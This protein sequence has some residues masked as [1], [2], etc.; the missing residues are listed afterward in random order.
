MIRVPAIA[1]WSAD[2]DAGEDLFGAPHRDNKHGREC[3]DPEGSRNE[4]LNVEQ[5]NGQ[6]DS[7]LSDRPDRHN[8][9]DK[10]KEKNSAS[11]EPTQEA[12]GVH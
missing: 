8:D 2:Q 5:E 4:D 12:P 6:L 1:Y 9:E 10:L 11:A 3:G 7:G